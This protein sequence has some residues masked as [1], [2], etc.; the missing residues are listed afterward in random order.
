[1]AARSAGIAALALGLL[2]AAAAARSSAPTLT[3]QPTITGTVEA[4]IRL[5]A[6]SGTWT[7]AT[8]ISYTYQWYRCDGVGAHCSSIHGATGPG[9]TL[10]SK[11][12]AKTIGLTVT[13]TDGSG[14]TSAYA[15]LVGP[16][17]SN[18][19]L[20][21]STAQPQI[22]GLPVE[23]KPLQVTTGAW[24][25]VPTSLAYSWRRCNANG[26]V[27][28]AI[29]GA[30]ASAYTVSGE[31]AGHALVALVQAS[32]G[33]TTQAALSTASPIAI[34]GDVAGP[35]HSAQ[36]AIRGVAEQ[37]AQLTG[38]AGLWTGIGSLT[39]AYQWNRCN[40][41]GAHCS[42]IHGATKT[43]YRTVAADSGKTLGFTVRTTDSTGTAAAYSSLI[44]PVAPAHA[45][46]ASAAPPTLTGAA[47]PGSTLV[48]DPGS[49]QPRVGTLS[50]AWRRCNANGRICTP[51]AGAAKASYVVT[52]ADVGH[53]LV[54]VVSAGVGTTTQAAY[55]N[56]TPP[57][58]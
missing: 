16:V 13:A 40:A 29:A 11:D 18:K 49:W 58:S 50:Y 25:P 26:R 2:A 27:C 33:T 6:G 31:D 21:V 4:G 28:A 44:G 3:A 54:A 53:A 41:D 1:V 10:V 36:P 14:S 48:A 19:P 22:T 51:I 9:L 32:F 55:S 52:T 23:G 42:S 38:S 47:R 5:A 57:V 35:S 30:N 39:Y 8:T 37:G 15:S 20:L 34:G 7:S 43:T 45:V 17:A 46:V 56:A 12:V 24:S